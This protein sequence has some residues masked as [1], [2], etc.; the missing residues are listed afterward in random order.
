MFA[1]LTQKLGK[2]FDRMRGYGRLSEKN[3]DEA[4]RDVRLSLLEADVNFKVVKEFT[5]AVKGRALGA[6][7][8]ESLTPGQQ[9]IKIVHQELVKVLGEPARLNLSFKPP[10]VILLAGLQGSGKTTTAGKLALHLKKKEKREPYLVP[11]DVYRPAAIDQLKTL[12]ERLGIP[13]HPTRENDDPVKVAK[14]AKKYAQDHGYD[15]VIIDTAGRLH[16]DETLMKELQKIRDKVEPQ[17]ILLVVDAMTGQEAVKVAQGFHQT[18]PLDG[19]I[20]TKL[21]GDAR[22]GAALSLRHVLGKPILFAGVG[23]KLEDLEPFH[24]D[25]MASRV[26]GMGDILTLIEQAQDKIDLK[27]AQESTERMLKKG[28]SLVD[29]QEQLGQMKRLGSLEKVVGL[30]PGIGKMKEGIDFNQAEKDLKK[31]GAILSSMTAQERLNPKILNGSRRLRIAKGSGTQVSDVN[32]LLKEFEEMKKMVD[33]LG[34][35]GLKGMKQLGSLFG[36]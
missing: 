22:G 21:D 14:E 26:L 24:P 25:R 6:D 5:E 35:F 34:K 27:K 36:R 2:V 28:F 3:I 23:E 7:V 11:A 15:V 13:V 10:V 29:F 9:F 4:L 12:G 32:R 1:D 30:I 16:I 20:F 19:V 17:Q 18:I 31:K 8:M 33:R